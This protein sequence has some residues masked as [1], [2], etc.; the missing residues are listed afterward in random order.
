MAIS[1]SKYLLFLAFCA[2]F[3]G[4]GLRAKGQAPDSSFQLLP[5]R[6]G[7]CL[8]VDTARYCWPQDQQAFRG[9]PV[10]ALAAGSATNTLELALPQ[11]APGQSWQ[12][13]PSPDYRLIDS[14][15][16]RGDSLYQRLQLE[17]IYRLDFPHLRL[18]LRQADGKSEHYRL[19]L[20]PYLPLVAQLRPDSEELFLGEEKLIELHANFPQAILPQPTWQEEQSIHYR[21]SREGER[22]LLHLLPTS[23]GKQQLRLPLRSN[24]SLLRDGQL[25]RELAPLEQEFTVK[26]SRLAFLRLSE[27]EYTYYPGNGEAIE[28]QLSDHRLLQMEKTYRIENQEEPGG[29]LVAELFTKSKLSNNQVLAELRVYAYHRQSEGYLYL[30]DGDQARFISNFSI[31]PKT[32]IERIWLQRPGGDWQESNTVYPGEKLQLR[33]E[34]QG[35]HKGQFRFMG[36]VAKSGDSTVRNESNAYY[37]LQIPSDIS[38]SGIEIFH[39]NRRLDQSLKVQEYR[40]P[41]DFNFVELELGLHRYNLGK[42]N[43]NIYYERTLDD[44][45]IQFDQRKID[46]QGELYG[47]QHIEIKVRVSNKDGNLIE[48]YAFDDLVICP[49]ENSP[50]HPFYRQ[51]NCAPDEI[52]LNQ[53]LSRKTSSLPEWSTIDLEIRH[54]AEAH[55]GESK[56][57]RIKII[58][59]RSINF[60]ID[61]SFP[62]GLLLLKAGESE[63]GNFGGISLAMIGQLSFYNPNKIAKYRPFKVGAGFVAIDAFNFSENANNRDVGLVL[64]GSLYPTSSENRLSF[65]LYVGYGYLLRQDKSFFL[66]G[67]GIRVRF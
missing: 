21:L 56:T 40:R 62:A 30:K 47:P 5:E 59:K 37:E 1:R 61:V 34:G 27:N 8:R 4:T 55:G 36:A 45:V 7:L 20:E 39:N 24:Q 41:Q 58:L 13:M 10:L 63:I 18:R 6:Y 44:V 19:Y 26:T 64:I 12:L 60:D 14:L 32:E 16:S 48:L 28:V 54:R 50:R 11:P 29:R 65:P 51:S 22:L 15:Q 52:S 23:S 43:H 31:S 66:I 49:G 25:S 17:Q 9:R 2:A 33:L 3:L 46:Y 42:M 38:S 35:L 67:P 57:K 53:Y